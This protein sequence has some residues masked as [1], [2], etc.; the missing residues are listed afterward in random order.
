MRIETI[1]AI[2][3]A[4]PGVSAIR[5]IDD[6]HSERIKYGDNKARRPMKRRMIGSAVPAIKKATNARLAAEGT[7]RY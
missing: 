6:G 1:P 2:Q 3:P 4:T 7:G 5:K